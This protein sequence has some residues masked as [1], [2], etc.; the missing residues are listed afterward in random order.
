MLSVPGTELLWAD[1]RMLPVLESFE[2]GDDF[3][4][5]LQATLSPRKFNT[6]LSMAMQLVPEGFASASVGNQEQV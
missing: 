5:T 1:C 4:S 2:G 6:F 3:L